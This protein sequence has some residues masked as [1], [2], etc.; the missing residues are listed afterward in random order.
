MVI[1]AFS[2]TP[3]GAGFARGSAA[4]VPSERL[5]VEGC[6][7]E[8]RETFT[9]SPEAERLLPPPPPH[10]AVTKTTNPR[11]TV[12]LLFRNSTIIFF[13]IANLRF[14]EKPLDLSL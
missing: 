10:P 5:L 4:V 3:G 2:M 11:K 13:L 12:Q 8:T 9:V 7:T 1:Q 6:G 14:S